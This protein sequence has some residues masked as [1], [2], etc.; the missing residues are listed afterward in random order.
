[1]AVSDYIARMRAEIGH[2]LLLLPGA[3]AVVTDDDGRVLLARRS[4]NGRWSVPAGV[5][6]PGEQPADAAVREVFEETGVRAEIVRLAGVAT[7]P[8]VY[9]NGDRCEYLN[10][11]FR[12]R[13]V[14]GEAQATDDE[15]LEVAWFAPHALPELDEWSVLRITTALADGTAAWHTTA[16]EKHPA[17]NRPDNL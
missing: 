13:A 6:D 12:C 8:V 11:W 7:H 9:P 14:G 3:S 4:D 5:I 17:L 2:D 15:S 1:M 16:R 10:V